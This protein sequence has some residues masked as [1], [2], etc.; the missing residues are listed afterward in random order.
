MSST[1]IGDLEQ[2]SALKV[3]FDQQGQAVDELAGAIRSQLGNTVWEGPAAD[4][5]RDAWSGEFEPA[6]RKLQAAFQ[7]AGNE[8]NTRRT[9]LEQAT[10]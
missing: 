3:A 7:E 1:R 5:F 8:V 10:A 4:R 2:L 9:A 6:L